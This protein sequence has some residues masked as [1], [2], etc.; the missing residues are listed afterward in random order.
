M[1]AGADPVQEVSAD[2]SSHSVMNF[3]DK[4]SVKE[5]RK[6]TQIADCLRHAFVVF[7]VIIR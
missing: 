4:G 2:E 3:H 1:G 5:Q 6:H 7:L